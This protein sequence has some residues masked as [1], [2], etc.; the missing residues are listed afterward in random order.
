MTRSWAIGKG[1]GVS[2]MHLLIHNT[3]MAYT[4]MG[5]MQRS[6]HPGTRRTNGL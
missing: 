1:S 3:N 6:P 4:N 2:G 5:V